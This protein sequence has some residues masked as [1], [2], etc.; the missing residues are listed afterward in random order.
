[1]KY[2]GWITLVE[3]SSWST[4]V[5]YGSTGYL[6]KNPEMFWKPFMRENTM[7]KLLMARTK[8]SLVT[9]TMSAID[10]AITP[11]SYGGQPKNI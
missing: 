11:A 5:A 2:H 1:M 6:N 9:I 3:N 10:G 7:N 4:E 8:K